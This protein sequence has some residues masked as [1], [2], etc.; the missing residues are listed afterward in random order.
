MLD[1]EE[2]TALA[3]SATGALLATGTAGGRVSVW[4]CSDLTLLFG[5]DKL[6]AAGAPRDSEVK[7]LAF[8]GRRSGCVELAA[9][10]DS[11]EAHCMA[12][13]VAAAEGALM[14]EPSA[15]DCKVVRDAA[16]LRKPRGSENAALRHCRC[17]VCA[18][19]VMPVCTFQR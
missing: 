2:V 8:G 1:H 6:V 13:R 15:A 11:G 14:A 3:V 12:L 19:G 17:G 7:C 18:L 5:S 16:A 4:R 10:Y 9:T